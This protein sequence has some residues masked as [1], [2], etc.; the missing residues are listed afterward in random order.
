M[1]R[2]EQ[3]VPGGEVDTV[4][5]AGVEPVADPGLVPVAL[6]MPVDSSEEAGKN[7]IVTSYVFTEN[8][9]KFLRRPSL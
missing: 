2:G 5:E 6:K 7:K 9:K 1:E 8:M 4:L 3:E